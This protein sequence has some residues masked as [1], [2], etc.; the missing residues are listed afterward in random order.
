MVTPRIGIA[1]SLLL[2][3]CAHAPEPPPPSAPAARVAP[4]E[5]VSSPDGVQPFVRAIVAGRPMRLL[6]DTG[7]PRSILPASV[8]RELG[9]EITSTTSN[10]TFRDALGTAFSLGTVKAVPVRFE[11]EPLPTAMDFGAND[12]VETL[13]VLSPQDLVE[14]GWAA[15]ID[16]ERRELRLEPEPDAVARVGRD[17]S[18]LRKL[19]YRTC[20]EGLWSPR[21]RVDL[22]SRPDLW[23]RR[24][25]VVSATVS[26]VSSELMIDTGASH[27]ALTR[28]SSALRSLS[29]V[30]GAPSTTRGH[31]STGAALLVQGVGV[32]FAGAVFF[33]PLLVLP[34]SSRCFEGVLGADVLRHCLVV[35][36]WSS[37]RVACHAPGHPD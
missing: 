3:A 30:T 28:N 33:E 27:S 6:L 11:G 9:L 12:A 22:R 7:A 37:L 35:W 14:P 24:Q 23:S 19:T 5:V 16:L 25:R 21:R 4:L 29:D 17:G 34:T 18:A 20:Q 32:E 31:A 26:G 13:A 1:A 36:A 8:V 15:V 10:A 2:A